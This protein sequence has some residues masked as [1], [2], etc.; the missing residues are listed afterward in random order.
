MHKM[1]AEVRRDVRVPL[2]DGGHRGRRYALGNVGRSVGFEP[3]KFLGQLTRRVL[4]KR[5]H[6][7]NQLKEA[8]KCSSNESPKETINNKKNRKSCKCLENFAP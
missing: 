3:G 5:F 4:K 7:L 8:P 2:L 1:V 6:F